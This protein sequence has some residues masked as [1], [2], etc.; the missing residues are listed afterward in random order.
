MWRRIIWE[1]T[2]G[3]YLFWVGAAY[4]T[5]GTI[6]VFIYKF[7]PVEY[8]QAVWFFVL[9]LPF[10][11][12]PLGRYIGLRPLWGNKEVVM[13]DNV[14]NNVVELPEP[15]AV[16]AM[17]PVAAPKKSKEHYRIGF[18]DQNET[19]LTIMA[20]GTTVTM[21]MNQEACEHMIKMLRATYVDE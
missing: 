8:I 17:P 3:Y 16:P 19:T 10:I 5:L 11:I 9:I 15:K 21:T 13:S 12:P 18:T 4:L 2:P 14:V 20:D 6:D 1:P 7:C